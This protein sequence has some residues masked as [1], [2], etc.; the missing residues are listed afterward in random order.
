MIS[1]F[2]VPIPEEK[3]PDNILK[4]NKKIWENINKFT[5]SEIKYEI[6]KN[7]YVNK[8]YTLEDLNK[9]DPNE[10]QRIYYWGNQ[11]KNQMCQFLK[12]FLDKEGLLILDEKCGKS[13]KG[14]EEEKDKK[15]EKKKKE[16]KKKKE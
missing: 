3:I 10:I 8:I 16:N 13:Q 7:D 5:T 6:L 4:N 1:I 2:K 12:D 9:L 14:E 15:K 11:Q